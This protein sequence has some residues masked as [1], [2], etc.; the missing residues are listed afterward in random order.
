MCL[1]DV[2]CLLTDIVARTLM[3]VHSKYVRNHQLHIFQLPKDEGEVFT[4]C[5][6]HLLFGVFKMTMG[7]NVELLT[8]RTAHVLP[9]VGPFPQ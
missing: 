9:F 1:W 7:H 6:T 5:G 3:K 2:A 8:Q 4:W